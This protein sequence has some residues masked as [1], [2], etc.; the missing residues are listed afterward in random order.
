MKR[1][2]DTDTCTDARLVTRQTVHNQQHQQQE[3]DTGAAT[4]FDDQQGSALTTKQLQ[5]GHRPPQLETSTKQ[6][7][8][9]QQQQHGVGG[10]HSSLEAPR[11][12]QQ[13][14]QDS[15]S[16]GPTAGGLPATPS[17][18]GVMLPSSNL[19][20]TNDAYQ[21][22]LAD[23]VHQTGLELRALEPLSLVVSRQPYDAML[24]C[25]G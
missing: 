24:C 25:L 2:K 8:H 22:H 19:G 12:H 4:A 14:Q 1:P 17:S 3:H 18:G 6:H 21:V 11:S 13:R 20:P 10:V 15:S 9:Q 23:R 7:S 16:K 5:D